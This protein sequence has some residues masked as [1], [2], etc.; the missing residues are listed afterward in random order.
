MNIF[1]SRIAAVASGALIIA[2][3]SGTTGAVAS[4]LI[5]GTDI[6]NESVTGTDVD[7]GTITGK[8]VK[9]GS[10][11][12]QDLAGE[13]NKE[14]ADLVAV[15]MPKQSDYFEGMKTLQVGAGDTTALGTDNPVHFGLVNVTITSAEAGTFD[16]SSN[17]QTVGCTVAA[18]GGSCQISQVIDARYLTLLSGSAATVTYSVLQVNP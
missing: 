9:N 6:K 1:K 15:S 16:L 8:D 18:A 2:A 10:L 11:T 5:D 4:G 3:L 13:S 17:G 14:L 12:L 7:N